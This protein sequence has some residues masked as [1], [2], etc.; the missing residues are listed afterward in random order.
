MRGVGRSGAHEHLRKRGLNGRL[1]V[2]TQALFLHRQFCQCS[3]FQA[4]LQILVFVND[5][6]CSTVQMFFGLLHRSWKSAVGPR[7]QNRAR[8]KDCVTAL[9]R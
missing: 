3:M 4:E 5:R 2:C 6:V 1:F 9:V 7:N 8:S